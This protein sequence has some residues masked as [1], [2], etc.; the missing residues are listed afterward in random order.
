M[1][2]NRETLPVFKLERYLGVRWSYLFTYANVVYRFGIENGLNRVGWGQVGW[3]AI[4]IK[5]PATC[6][7]TH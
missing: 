3:H 4:K 1:N 2:R 6:T 5:A 7:C